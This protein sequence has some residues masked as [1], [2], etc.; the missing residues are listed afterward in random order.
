VKKKELFFGNKKY[1]YGLVR[2]DRKTLSLTVYPNLNI[3]VKTPLVLVDALAESFLK[4]KWLWLDRQLRYFQKYQTKFFEKEYISGESFLYLGRQYKLK[5][6]PGNTISISLSKATLTLSTPDAIHNGKNNKKLMEEWYLRRAQKVLK[7]RYRTVIDKFDYKDTPR[8]VLRKMTKRWGS[9][10]ASSSK[11]ILNP[12]LIKVS[13]D[14]IDYV[15][16]HELCH[17]RFKNHNN[18]FYNLFS[19]YYPNWKKLKDKLESRLVA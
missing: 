12:E 14:C 11:V 10:W 13:T 9:Y 5:V 7:E 19:F 18:K 2:E 8:L 6:I 16:I 3:V 4:R 1:K 15:I 17:V